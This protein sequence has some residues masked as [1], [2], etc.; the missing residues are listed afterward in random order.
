MTSRPVC[1]ARSRASVSGDGRSR[2]VE[3]TKRAAASAPGVAKT[4]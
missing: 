2:S 1:L 4:P 3:P